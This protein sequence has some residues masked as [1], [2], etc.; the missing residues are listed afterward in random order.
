MFHN[1]LLPCW[2]PLIGSLPFFGY[3]EYICQ[4]HFCGHR[5]S[6]VLGRY[7]RVRLFG[8]CTSSFIRNWQFSKWLNY[9]ILPP[10]KYKCSNCSTSLPTLAIVSELCFNKL[11]F[12]PICFYTISEAEDFLSSHWA[13]PLLHIQYSLPER[14]RL[15]THSSSA[16]LVWQVLSS[17]WL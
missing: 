13:K 10:T 6:F 5:F 11:W 9:F 2:W 4:E 16:A 15:L 1:Y 8:K 12:P 3:F 7:L 17:C 14:R